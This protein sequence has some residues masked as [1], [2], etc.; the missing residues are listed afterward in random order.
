MMR[1]CAVLIPLIDI[2]VGYWMQCR[3]YEVQTSAGRKF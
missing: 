1:K 2:G 3:H